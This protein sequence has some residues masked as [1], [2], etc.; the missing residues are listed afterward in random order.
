MELLNFGN[1]YIRQEVYQTIKLHNTSNLLS[2]QFKVMKQDEQSKGWGELTCDQQS[3]Q[4]GPEQTV[5]LTVKV[6]LLRK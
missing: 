1:V 5:T 4:I 3:G 6:I 2:T